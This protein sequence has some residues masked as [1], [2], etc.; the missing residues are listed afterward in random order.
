MIPPSSDPRAI[1]GQLEQTARRRFGQHFLTRPDIVERIVRMS[2]AKPN[3]PVLEIGPGLGILTDA[4]LAAGVDLTALELDRDLVAHLRETRP[5]MRLIEGDAMKVNWTEVC[6]HRAPERYRVV[7]NLPYNVGTHVVMMMVRQPHVFSSL[8][9]MLQKEVV[10]RLCAEPGSKAYGALTVEVQA[11]AEPV[12]GFLVPPGAFHPPP[13]VDSAVLRLE[14]RDEPI[15]GDLDSKLFDRVVR[16]GF[17]QRRKT[18]HNALGATFG[19]E[20]A[21]A[22]IEQAGLETGIRAERVD[23]AGFVR[24]A[25]VFAEQP[26]TGPSGS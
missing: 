5:Q 9:V 12:F 13:K 4:L 24:L 10:Q 22:A 23:C 26:A 14:I 16:A 18:L 11:R 6:A 21:A 20:Q 3:D 17:S 8:T 7:A 1:L 19:R 2:R 15:Y 25:R